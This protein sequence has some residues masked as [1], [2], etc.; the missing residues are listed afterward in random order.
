HA[1]TSLDCGTGSCRADF[2][3]WPVDEE[4]STVKKNL[5]GL[6]VARL[7]P[8][9]RFRAYFGLGSGKSSLCLFCVLERLTSPRSYGKTTQVSTVWREKSGTKA[10]QGFV[11]RT[12]VF[13]ARGFSALRYCVTVSIVSPPSTRSSTTR[14]LFPEMFSMMVVRI[15]GFTLSPTSV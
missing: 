13:R 14:T 6:A 10:L 11:K 7:D 2:R 12:A 15:F 5:G 9:R 8:M 1:S 3:G 4:S